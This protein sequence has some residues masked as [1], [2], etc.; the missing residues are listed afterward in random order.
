MYVYNTKSFVWKQLPPQPKEEI[1][2]NGDQSLFK[3]TPIMGS[4][5]PNRGPF[6][7]EQLWRKKVPSSR[8]V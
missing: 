8:N 6:S 5:L 7:S 2:E 3:Y 1:P 4:L